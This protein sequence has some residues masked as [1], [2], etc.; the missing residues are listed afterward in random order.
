MTIA[1]RRTLDIVRLQ[2]FE[3]AARHGS[4][5]EAARELDLTQSAISRQ[6][7][8]LEQQLGVPLFE[9]IRKRVV[10]SGAG[11]RFLPEVRRILEQLE[12]TTLRVMAA[13]RGTT[14][15]IATLPTF[16]ERWL[17]PRLPDFLRQNP[18]VTLHFASHSKPFDLGEGSFDGAIHYGKPVWA[19]A[20]CRFICQEEMFVVAAPGFLSERQGAFLERIAQGPLLH[21]DT[22][23]G[24]WSDWLKLVDADESIAYQGHRFDQFSMIIQAAINGLGFGLVPRYLIEQ[25]LANI[26]LKIVADEPL[27]T[28]NAYYLVAPVSEQE[29]PLLE[30]FY[31]WMISK[32]SKRRATIHQAINR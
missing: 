28:E 31:Q 11:K 4:F 16:G 22:R 6:I 10:I 32:V 29:N 13:P 7:K 9:R 27:V 1:R 21:L 23:P 25:E 19:Q 20:T 14:L 5:T 24:A 26:S 2:A 30:V 15:S 8:E 12:Q 3:A 18:D 17:I